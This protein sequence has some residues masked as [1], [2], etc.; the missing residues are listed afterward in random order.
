MPTL[1]TASVLSDAERASV[2]RLSAQVKKN[3]PKL[4]RL[5]KY[6]EG[7]QR[8]KHI[9][10]AIPPEARIFE[11][12]V[13][14][15]RMAVMEP[16]LRQRLRGF[17][18]AGDSTV[19]DKDLRASWEANNLDSES[20]LCHQETRLFGRAFVAVGSHPDEGERPLITVESP[21]EI[22]VDVDR[23]RRAMREG[24]RQYRDDIEKVTRGTLYQRDS[25]LHVVRGSRGWQLDESFEV[26]RDSHNMGAVPLVMFLN[27]RRAGR[28]EGTSEMADVITKTD[29]IARLITNLL[30]GSETHAL[31]ARWIAGASN[32]DFMDEEGQPIPVWEAY[33]TAIRAI[34]DHD[35][36]FGE[37]KAG[38]LKNFTDTVDSML[39]WC[40][41]ELG[42]PT[43]YTGQR[44]VQPPTEGSV[45]AD[46]SRLIMRTEAKNRYDGDSWAWVMGMEER[47]RT[48][49][50]GTRNSIRTLWQSPATP[51]LA[52]SADAA[53]KLRAGG[54]LSVEGVWDMMDW[55]EPH[56]L[57]ERGRLSREVESAQILDPYLLAQADGQ[58]ADA[59]TLG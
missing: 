37:W 6:F 17:Y 29:G 50:W 52:Q 5:D 7:E 59:P 16:V 36:K 11:T 30:V 32:E 23:Q 2:N 24:F 38:D 20:S 21:M 35:A 58:S 39:A 43:R 55:D 14:V 41:V 46:E 51:T 34:D 33:F 13:N 18:R 54:A 49:E 10:L 40:A 44:T 8:L 48:G 57:L 22:A 31:P 27:G 3:R 42:L 53:M 45:V 15:P 28:Y 12:V 47:I 19:Q 25:T 4:D 9:G 1:L 26:A 56:K